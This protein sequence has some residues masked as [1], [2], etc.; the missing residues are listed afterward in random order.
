[1]RR[2][3]LSVIFFL[4][5][6]SLCSTLFISSAF[7]QARWI[8]LSNGPE[9]SQDCHFI[10][11]LTG[12]VLTDLGN[13]VYKTTDGGSTFSNVSGHVARGLRC[14]GFFD[15]NTGIVGV[16]SNP[17]T[18]LVRTTNGGSSWNLVTNVSGIPI[19][20][21]CG[22]SIVDSVTATV[23]GRYYRPANFLK[24]TDKGA[25]WTSIRPDTALVSSLVDCKFWNANTGFIVGGY[26]P[27]SSN[28]S[29]FSGRA[30]VLRTTNGGLN[31]TRMHTTSYDSAWCWKIQFLNSQIG[32]V[33]VESEVTGGYLK[34]TDGG[35]TWQEKPFTPHIDIEGIGFINENT[36]WIGGYGESIINRPP[37]YETT[38]AG[39]TWH[40]TGIGKV[41]NRIRVINDT[42]AYAVGSSRML[43]WTTETVGIIQLS[44][45][46]PENFSL[47]QNYPNP[48]NP[49]TTINY[50]IK[51]SGFVNLSIYDPKG[52][53][54]NS[55]V[56]EE[57]KQGSYSASFDALHLPSGVYFYKL[58]IDNFSETKKML[59]VK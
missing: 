10:N 46:V 16:L 21:S 18:I 14:I 54:I 26:S 22:I 11:A 27:G 57:Q 29:Y 19:T 28:S 37:M 53:F 25:T 52:A 45:E 38:D 8:E 43:K 23:V 35:L 24:T 36:G 33:S 4:P 15:A 41:I 55:L 13:A 1:M 47:S 7:P 40:S 30:V 6:F 20:G 34:T 9:R 50:S 58:T 51:K 49:S 3:V 17:D 31:F 48:F 32:Y 12:Y 59:L 56:N 2:T 42:V 5:L 39:V 44:S